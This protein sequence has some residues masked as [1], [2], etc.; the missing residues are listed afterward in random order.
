MLA[1]VLI[2]VDGVIA[3]TARPYNGSG[4]VEVLASYSDNRESLTISQPG[5][6]GQFL[7]II[8]NVFISQNLCDGMVKVAKVVD[9]EISV[10]DSFKKIM[11]PTE[12]LN[13]FFPAC[14]EGPPMISL[15]PS[16]WGY[17]LQALTNPKEDGLEE[18]IRVP[19]MDDSQAH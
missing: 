14:G 4:K 17:V 11:D 16:H 7:N 19:H 5:S 10:P 12:L 9:P 3:I 1:A 15:N 18:F 13:T 8:W 2:R 6:T